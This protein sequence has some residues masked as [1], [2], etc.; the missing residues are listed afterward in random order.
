MEDIIKDTIKCLDKGKEWKGRYNMYLK[1][2]Y[3]NSSKM[4]KVFHKPQGLSL[5]TTI[6]DRNNK[7]YYLR[8]KGQNVAMIKVS[9]NGDIM[10]K[11]LVKESKTHNI[12]GCPLEYKEEVSWDS[13]KASEFRSFFKKLSIETKTKSPEHEVENALLEE[14][15]KHCGCE[16]I[17][18]NIQP[19][20]L[21]NHFFQMP[22]PLKASTHKPTY[23]KHNGGGIDMLARIKTKQGHTRLCVIEIKDENKSTES[24]KIAMSQAIV[25]AIF[26]SKL[27]TECPDW[28]EFFMGHKSRLGRNSRSLDSYDIE[29]VTIMPEGNTETFEDK[30]LEIPGSEYKLHC[31]SLY[32]NPEVFARLHSFRLSGTFLNEIK[33]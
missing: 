23:S 27:L 6:G 5:Y 17:L 16:K 29:V 18:H 33:S 32:Y 12:K 13:N 21:Q 9:A 11:C 15:R 31:H 22:T 7:N 10:L 4:V 20:L 28:M 30:I 3:Y 24:Q 8:F 26:I 25:Y 14:F 1:E 19:V 2:I